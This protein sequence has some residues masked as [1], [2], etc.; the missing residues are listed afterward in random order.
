MAESPVRLGAPAHGQHLDAP[1]H[2]DP[3]T[4]VGTCVGGRTA[5]WRVSPFDISADT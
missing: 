3:K 4:G 1:T 2:R 5:N